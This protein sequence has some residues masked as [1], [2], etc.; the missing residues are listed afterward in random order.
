MGNWFRRALVA[1]VIASGAV[2]PNG[3]VTLADDG[4]AA[5]IARELRCEYT[6]DP[7]GVDVTKPRLSWSLASVVQGDRQTAYQIVAASSLLRS[8]AQHRR[9]VG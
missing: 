2:L 6:V 3:R 4:P 1:V 8:R 7:L 9:A 5:L